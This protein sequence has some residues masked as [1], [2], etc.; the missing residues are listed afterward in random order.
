MRSF[1]ETRQAKNTT[2]LV[3]LDHL[4]TL[5]IT[6]VFIYHFGRMFPHPEWT[7]KISKFGWTG[8]DLFFVLSGYLIAS[9]LFST[10]AKGKNISLKAFFVKR[11]FRIIP[12]Y[13]V[14]V[15]IYFLFPYSHE[16]ESLAPLWKYLTFT[17]N[18]GLDLRTQGTF[19]HA[20]SLCIEE[21]FYLFLP[22]ILF[23]LTYFRLIK[24]GFWVLISLFLFGFFIRFYSYEHFVTPNI[25][26]EQVWAFWYKWVY[27]PTYCRLDGLLVGVSIAAVFQFKPIIRERITQFGN[28]LVL[29]SIGILAL[30]Y[31]VC[32]DEMSFA[33]S[34][35]G[36]PIVSLGYG[37]LVLAAISPSS[38]LY[39]MQS[40]FTQYIAMLSYGIYLTHKIVIHITQDQF[41]KLNIEKDSNLMFLI[42]ILTSIAIAALM[43]KIIEKPFLKIR[44][45]FLNSTID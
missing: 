28:S 15:A 43:N 1:D 30:A 5:A 14:V 40:N 18:L 9:Q 32:S 24:N 6:M 4:R 29:L 23:T 11:F 17:Q 35:W 13:L 7:E 34:V 2:K 12:P 8:V 22:L 26:N 45:K 10:I 37:V 33:A 44:D 42:C 27:Y 36:F 19:S 3:G 16:R 38:F 20:W 39:R 21:Q 25:D 31:N 41:A